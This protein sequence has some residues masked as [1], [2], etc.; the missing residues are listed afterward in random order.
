M[1]TAKRELS[2]SLCL[3]PTTRICKMFSTAGSLSEILFANG[4]DFSVTVKTEDEVA[5]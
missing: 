4:A 5:V 3:F 1:P 2:N